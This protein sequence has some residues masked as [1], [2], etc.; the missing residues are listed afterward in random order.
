MTQGDIV[1]C[2]YSDKREPSITIA[3]QYTVLKVS[4]SSLSIRVFNDNG[5]VSDY[6]KYLFKTLPEYREYILNELLNE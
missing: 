2:I 3:K 6:Y 4:H 5:V 1:V